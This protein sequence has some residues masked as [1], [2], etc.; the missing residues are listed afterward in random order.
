MIDRCIPLPKRRL[1][2]RRRI[3]TLTLLIC[4][5]LCS[6]SVGCL[7]LPRLTRFPTGVELE[8]KVDLDF[9]QIGSTT[10][11]EVVKKLLAIDT[12]LEHERLFWG[13]W[14]TSQGIFIVGTAPGGAGSIREWEAYNAMIE[15][16]E[17]GF[18]KAYRV[19]PDKSVIKELTSWVAREPSSEFCTPV[20]ITVLHRHAWNDKSSKLTLTEDFFEF[21]ESKDGSHNFRISPEK[22]ERVSMA[23]RRE[24]PAAEHF[25]SSIHF[26]EKTKAGRRIAVYIDIPE[27]AVLLNYLRPGRPA[28]AEPQCKPWLAAKEKALHLEHPGVAWSRLAERYQDQGRYAEAEES[29]QFA[30]KIVEMTLGPEHPEVATSMNN[31]AVLYYAQGKYAE[32]EP[33]YERALAIREKALGPEHVNV[34]TTLENYAELLRKTNRDTEAEKLEARAKAI[35]AKHVQENPPE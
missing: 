26:R 17:K 9:I 35:R 19:V 25:V 5:L 34:A 3:E 8:T 30:M 22:V 11:Q 20:E 18:V 10:R 27:L 32:A 29:Y 21:Q 12:G 13:R 6:L 23:G 14:V 4:F 24:D 33:L 7:P 16:D 1:L 28:K 2:G 31:L 15:F